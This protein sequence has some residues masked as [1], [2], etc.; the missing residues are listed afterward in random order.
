MSV[1]SIIYSWISLLTGTGHWGNKWINMAAHNTC[2]WGQSWA[3]VSRSRRRWIVYSLHSYPSF[4]SGHHSVN[5]L[6]RYLKGLFQQNVMPGHIAKPDQL[7]AAWLLQVRGFLPFESRDL[8]SLFSL[9]SLG[10]FNSLCRRSRGAYSCTCFQMPGFS[11]TYW[12]AESMF[13]ASKAGLLP[14]TDW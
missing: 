1:S 11:S 4:S 2:H 5:L 12:Q 9:V 13:H 14:W 7:F 8:A 6:P 10:I 3:V